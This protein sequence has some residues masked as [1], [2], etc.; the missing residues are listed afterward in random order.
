MPL[1]RP[2]L[3]LC[4]AKSANSLSRTLD[5]VSNGLR[6]EKPLDIAKTLASRSRLEHRAY[7]VYDGFQEATFQKGTICEEMKLGFIFT[8]GGAQWPRMGEQLL[9]FP[10]CHRSV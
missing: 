9:Q 7:A 5:V 3:I 10:A 4:S 8:G 1:E 2:V 6:L